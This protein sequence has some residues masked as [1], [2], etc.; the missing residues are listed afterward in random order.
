MALDVALEDS[1]EMTM[2]TAEELDTISVITPLEGVTRLVVDEGK[3]PGV[4]V[5]ICVGLGI[6]IVSTTLL[7]ETGT[8][9]STLLE[10]ITALLGEIETGDFATSGE[11]LLS[12]KEAGAEEELKFARDV[13][14]AGDAEDETTKVE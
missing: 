6:V 1:N 4:D 7:G 12:G 14:T 9:D 3:A 8:G 5:I 2:A 13:A 10:A 11:L